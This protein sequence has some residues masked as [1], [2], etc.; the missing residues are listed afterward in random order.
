MHVTK[1]QK[2]YEYSATFSEAIDT[3]GM[4]AMLLKWC[5]AQFDGNVRAISKRHKKP[6]FHAYTYSRIII[7]FHTRIS[8]Y[9]F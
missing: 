8:D 3:T 5:H 4:K 7:I 1:S 9:K 2:D 6:E